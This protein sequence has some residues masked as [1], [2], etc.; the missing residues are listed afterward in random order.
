MR[1][2]EYY[3]RVTLLSEDIGDIRNQIKTSLSKLGI[4]AVILTPSA[5]VQH[6]NAPG[7]ILDPLKLEI[8]I[9]EFVIKN[10]GDAGSKQPASDVAE[11]TMWLLHYPNHA[12]HRNDPCQFI[13]QSLR[14]VPDNQFLIYR[15]TFQTT[16]SLAGITTE[17][18]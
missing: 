2:D 16:G 3:A 14:L 17:E 1:S 18:A 11:H 13:A 7:P 4:C 15:V 9:T 10:R 8:D 12:H 5:D 6:T